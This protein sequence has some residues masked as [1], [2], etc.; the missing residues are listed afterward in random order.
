[1]TEPGEFTYRRTHRASRELL[2]DCMTQPKHLTQFWGPDGTTTPVDGIT[3]ELW[4]GGAFETL[5]VNVADGSQ[6]TMRAVFLAVERPD[7]LVWSEPGLEGGM[8]TTV[9]FTELGDGWTEVVT[10]QTNVPAMFASPEVRAGFETS[11]RRFDDYLVR[12]MAG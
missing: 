7:R 1:V 11:L 3:V 9:T 4:P 10:H 8:T 5:M 12:L 6:Y 2:F